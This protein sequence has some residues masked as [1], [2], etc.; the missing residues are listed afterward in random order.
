VRGVTDHVNASTSQRQFAM[1]TTCRA[2]YG[3]SLLAVWSH[4]TG[5]LR[6]C[7]PRRAL[8]CIQDSVERRRPRPPHQQDCLT[9]TCVTHSQSLIEG[10]PGPVMGGPARCRWF[11]SSTARTYD[12]PRA[13]TSSG[14]DIV[15]VTFNYRL[16]GLGGPWRHPGTLGRAARLGN[17]GWPTAGGHCR[18]VRDNI[19]NLRRRSRKVTGAAT[20]AGGTV[21]V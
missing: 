4:G 3:G 19:A 1:R 11:H 18:C 14:R 16:G 20:S 15:V 10:T 17:T 5:H 8:R 2:I 12:A 21:G 6:M 7:H 9:A 13:L